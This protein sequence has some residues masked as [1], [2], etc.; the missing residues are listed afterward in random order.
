MI[1][2]YDDLQEGEWFRDLSPLLHTVPIR[3]IGRRNTN[4]SAIERLL[5][6]DRPDIILI[7]D[8]EPRLVVE[9]T[10][11]VP[12]GH[13]VGQRF[14]RFANAVEEQVMVVFFLPFVAMKHGRYAGVCYIPA[15]FFM[16]LEKMEEIHGIPVLAVNWPCDDRFELVRDGSQ[17]EAMKG[18]VDELVINGFN[19]SRVKI[20]DELRDVMKKMRAERSSIQPLTA[21]PPPSVRTQ[22][23]RDYVDY[24][25]RVFPKDTEA[26]P[27]NCLR[28]E[29]TLIYRLGMTPQKCRREDPYTGTQFIYDYI[30]CRSGPKPSDKH[31]NLVLEVPLV[32]KRRWLE[33]NPN[34]PTRK[35][36]VYYATADFIVLKDG[37][38][39]CDSQIGLGS[40]LTQTTGLNKFFRR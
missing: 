11:E 36:S 26:L 24:L 25:K 23:T 33:A 15:R 12:T 14:G 37:L 38:I 28:R 18:L 1:I 19:Y 9:K 16:A 10:S 6:Y 7:A 32:S 22:K 21:K 29:D 17:D 27:K 40:S 34:D 4:P 3:P 35:S 20:I 13:N 8:N 2:Y 31:A 5:R 30:W 39:I